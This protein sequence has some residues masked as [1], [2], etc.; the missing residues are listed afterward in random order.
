MAQDSA[1]SGQMGDLA[2]CC[3]QAV[4]E[5][6]ARGAVGFWANWS[7]PPEE[8]MTRL[9]AQLETA[10]EQ[11]GLTLYVNEPYGMS[12]QRAWVLFSSA[13]SGGTLEGRICAALKQYGRER[14]VLAV[15][16]M[17]EDFTL[18]A[19][20]GQGRHLGSGPAAELARTRGETVF[21]SEELCASYCTFQEGDRTHL[22]LFDTD[23]DVREKLRLAQRLGVERVLL[24][25]GELGGLG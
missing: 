18:P 16:R 3:A 6:A 11:A 2:L 22:L 12:T 25:L 23:E 9:T 5:C 24:A 7:R 14:V 15:E 19:P 4:R 13:L 1:L 17:G 10:L 20:D 21:H 8:N